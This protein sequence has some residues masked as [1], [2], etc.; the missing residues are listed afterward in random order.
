MGIHYGTSMVKIS[1]ERINELTF[2]TEGVRNMTVVAHVDHGKSTLT[3]SLVSKAGIISAA[4]AGEKRFTDTRADEQERCITI[5]STG[6]SLYFEDDCLDNEMKPYLINLIDSPGHVD[7]SSEVTA[8]LRVT[9]GALVVVDTVSGVCVQTETVLRQA[10]EERIRPVLHVNKVDRAL[11]ELKMDPEDMYLSFVKA[12]ESVNV[13]IDTYDDRSMGD[14]Q[15]DPTKGVVSFGSGLQGWAFTLEQFAA[16]YCT[17]FGVSYDVMMKKLWGENYFDSAAKKIVNRKS[18]NG[19]RCFNKF[20]IG[21][22]C[23]V[24]KAVMNDDKDRYAVLLEKL[25]IK[26]TKEEKDLTSKA[27]L[28]RVMQLWLPAGDCMLRM[29]VKHL[30]SP[31]VAQN[32][33]AD[34][35]YSGPKD[36]EAYKSIKNCDP[37]GVLMMY[38]SKMVPS[39]EKGRFFAFGRVFGGTAAGGAKVR[40]QGPNYEPGKKTD[41]NEKP[42][43]RTAIMMGSRV[44]QVP[45]IPAGNTGVLI[46][47]DTCLVKTGTITDWE[48]A[49]NV[50]DMKYSVSPVVRVSVRPK[51][52]SQVQK[53][54]EGLK[55][56]AKSD[57]LVQCESTESGEFIVA[58][59]GEL[60]MEICLKDLREDY[61][62]IELIVADPVVSYKETVTEPSSAQCMSKSA[63]KHNRLYFDCQPLPIALVEEIEAERLLPRTEQKEK[64]AKF[65]EHDIVKTEVLRLWGWGPDNK[66]PNFIFDATSGI[67]YMNE[68]K[69][70]CVNG[71]QWVS[72]EGV[73]C[74]SPLRGARFNLYDATLHA[75]A[76]H[77]GAGQ[78]VEP[79]RK[80]CYGAQLVSEP[81]LVEPIFLVDIK[82]PQDEVG[83]VYSILA[84]N[85]GRVVSETNVFPQIAIKAYLP[86]AESFGFT[87]KLREATG[88]KAFP[89]CTFD[90]W[91]EVSGDP[92][93]ESG[94][95]VDIIKNIRKR[96][97]LK[98]T[99]FT[100]DFYC[101]KL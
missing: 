85:R 22:I 66:G 33:R 40:I 93:A 6:I 97:H 45:D 14:I 4:A 74:E 50:V 46:G 87:G 86:V 15:L 96:K 59:C 28:K 60:H 23:E 31:K 62:Q 98:E 58:G 73:L 36:D 25:D 72:R 100:H 21:P 43:Q 42:I 95:C 57:P 54:A 83:G 16:S 52:P 55:R 2:N 29:I 71:F 65:A 69:E 19:V 101:D 68:I 20:I 90:H 63:N 82:V 89:Q 3:D 30:P 78:I 11:L 75:D 44:E 32:Y 26:L 12:V 79:T 94:P 9:D 27:L 13:I 88:G 49:H 64:F 7:F 48:H 47:I 37:K 76:I 38:V 5:K 1:P 10:I 70:H 61:A 67:Q 24:F 84:Q 91:A 51:D 34:I 18:D 56:L 17:K 39:G 53:L 35:L 80:A 77:R 92:L 81:R 99:P 41:L 8:A